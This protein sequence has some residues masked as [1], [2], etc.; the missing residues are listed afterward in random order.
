MKKINTTRPRDAQL[1]VTHDLY[2]FI[3]F[4]ATATAY[5]RLHIVGT[6]CIV[7]NLRSFTFR[8]I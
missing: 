1:S 2:A 5:N 3:D 4:L 6:H 8:G 7:E